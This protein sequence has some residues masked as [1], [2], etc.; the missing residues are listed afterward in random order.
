MISLVHMVAGDITVAQGYVLDALKNNFPE[1][2]PW[3]M[4][5]IEKLITT[6]LHS[7]ATLN[8]LNIGIFFY[9]AMGVIGAI[10]F[11]LNK[12]AHH[13]LRGGMLF[14]DLRA[15]VAAVVMT[16]FLSAMI[17]LTQQS[18]VHTLFGESSG[19]F[20]K[21]MLYFFQSSFFL[22]AVAVGFFTL[23]FK[24]ATPK[25]ISFARSLL[26]AL[27]FVMVFSAGRTF[28]WVY[29]HYAKA[30]LAQSFG[31]FYTLVVVVVW[32]YFAQCALF[33][34]ASVAYQDYGNRKAVQEDSTSGEVEP[35]LDKVA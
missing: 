29:L 1:M 3:I 14:D 20:A 5:S 2:A 31:N 15:L 24:V 25:K 6:Q 22:P 7:S 8:W 21:F 35:S 4:Q 34:G 28:Y 12:I 16:T 19:P 9:S 30:E 11:G 23:F 18:V 13:E 33:Y 27:S 17:F 26:G 10:V 32:M